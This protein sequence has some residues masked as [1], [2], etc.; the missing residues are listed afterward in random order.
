MNAP[1]TV[2]IVIATYNYGMFIEGAIE[3]VLAQTYSDFEIIVVDDGSCDN[4]DKIIGTYLIDSRIRYHRTDHLGQSK[5]KNTGIR[6]SRGSLVAVLDA[7]DL[8]L[9][10]KL[11]RQLELFW[12]DPELGVAYTRRILINERGEGVPYLQPTFYRGDV[13]EQMFRN[14]FICHSSVLIRKEVLDRVGVFDESI[15]MAI[16]FDLWLRIALQFRF[17]YVDEALVKYR[18]G[19]ASLSRRGE[20]RLLIATDIMKRFLDLNE[21]CGRISPEVIRHSWAETFCH[22]GQAVRPRSRW[23]AL[24]WYLRSIARC[25]LYCE[26]WRDLASLVLPMPLKRLL[27]RSVG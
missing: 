6:L 16:D 5:A 22:L 12:K 11:E 13:L 9:P 26:P 20:E 19:H 25:P 7:D 1:P 18:T 21:V 23:G 3:S 10:T 27:R 2:S 14:N 15:P 8:W 17:D 4:T 24:V